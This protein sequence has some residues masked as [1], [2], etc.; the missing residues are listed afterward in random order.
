MS[1]TVKYIDENPSCISIGRN[2]QI[3]TTGLF[4]TDCCEVV[5]VIPMTSRG[6]PGNCRI[7]IP[8]RDVAAAI[9]ALRK[10]V[11]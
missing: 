11:K 10:A 7:E 2:G 5:T 9:A 8:K 3:K 6:E 1:L 4:V